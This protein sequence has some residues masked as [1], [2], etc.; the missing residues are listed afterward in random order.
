MTTYLA[1]AALLGVVSLMLILP[2]V[3]AFV[4]L[5]RKS[6]AVP[7]SVVPEN[8][9]EIRHFA[10]SFR[11][12][13]RK[14][15]PT[16][17]QCIALRTTPTGTLAD[18]TDY[19]V[20]SHADDTP[21]FLDSQNSVRRLVIAVGVDLTVRPEI[22]FSNDIYARGQLLGGEKNTYR[23]ILGERDVQL[24]RYSRVM[25]WVHSGGD[26]N[27]E[28]GCRLYGR[29]SSDCVLRLRS[30]C[31]FAR[32]NAPRI[33]I[34]QAENNDLAQPESDL[35]AS[36]GS[37]MPRRYLQDGDFAIRPGQVIRGNIV[38]R[39]RLRIGFGARVFGSVKGGR[40]VVL[41]RNV[42][43]EGSL[44]GADKVHIGPGCSVHGPVVAEREMFIASGTRCGSLQKPTTVSAP[45]ITVEEGVV[46]FGTLW[47]RES[48]QV[49]A[50]G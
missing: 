26:L 35:G 31:S 13:I 23:A 37:V 48:G 22:S 14:L 20:L 39:G 34:G 21:V 45:R 25:R 29:A 17:Q 50:K 3:P 44:V 36:T 10:N 11:T 2:V 47:A 30:R 5:L 7:L 33:Q 6:D 16:L 9:G 24:G 27:A 28:H 32:L 42:L 41:E 15:E 38:I 40:D 1:F 19:L 49:V 12:F 4:E 43:V 18:G 8:A 46:V